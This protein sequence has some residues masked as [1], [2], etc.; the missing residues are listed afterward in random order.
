MLTLYCVGNIFP[1]D[2]E[3]KSG[4]L[5]AVLSASKLSWISFFCPLS[6]PFL[7]QIIV[8]YNSEHIMT[9]TWVIAKRSLWC[10]G[11]KNN[12]GKKRKKSKCRKKMY[13][14]ICKMKCFDW[15]ARDRKKLAQYL[16][17]QNP[18]DLIYT[19]NH[20]YTQLRCSCSAGCWCQLVYAP[21]QGIG[22]IGHRIS[23]C[24]RSALECAW[25]R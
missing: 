18:N 5:G 19:L 2:P 9:S 13:L 22:S 21:R 11:K 1:V 15:E 23:F 7:F 8:L 17:K 10:E 24:R 12:K 3:L 20:Q 6:D 4:W 16:Q 14:I 25:T